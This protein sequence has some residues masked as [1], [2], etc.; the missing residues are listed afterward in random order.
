LSRD[1]A[2]RTYRLPRLWI[3]EVIPIAARRVV[4]LG[5]HRLNSSY[6]FVS[7]LEARILGIGVMSQTIV[8]HATLPRC[9]PGGEWRS[10][11]LGIRGELHE[12]SASRMHFRGAHSTCWSKATAKRMFAVFGRPHTTKGPQG[13]R[14]KLGSSRPALKNGDR[15]HSSGP[16]THGKSRASV[17]KGRLV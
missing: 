14:S 5:S 11:P 3:L 12:S 6:R 15:Q 1:W 10:S 8:L 7:R 9:V 4:P 2:R 17:P 13:A 16:G